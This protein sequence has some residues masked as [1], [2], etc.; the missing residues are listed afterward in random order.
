[1]SADAQTRGDGVAFFLDCLQNPKA[2]RVAVEN[3]HP[4][5]GMQQ[6]GIGRAPDFARCNPGS[7][8]IHET[9]ANL[10]L[11]CAYPCRRLLRMMQAGGTRAPSWTNCRQAW[12]SWES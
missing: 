6:A 12:G 7:S 5:S 4:S 2:P 1:M 8:G 9:K 3:P 10:L 11:D